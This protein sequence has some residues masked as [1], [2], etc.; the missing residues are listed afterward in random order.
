MD[1]ARRCRNQK[2][3]VGNGRWPMAN[4][5]SLSSLRDR[6]FAQAAAIPMDSSTD[7]HSYEVL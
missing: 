1:T 2:Y 5:K 7:K 3:K 6:E 4:G